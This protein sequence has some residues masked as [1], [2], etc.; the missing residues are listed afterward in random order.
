L[1]VV[2]RIH[3]G[4]SRVVLDPLPGCRTSKSEGHKAG[5]SGRRNGLFVGRS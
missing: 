4:A 5:S 1:V 3:P 2:P